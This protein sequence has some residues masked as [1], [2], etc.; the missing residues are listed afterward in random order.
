VLV[1]VLG[2]AS[3]VGAKSKTAVKLEVVDVN[4]E[5]HQETWHPLNQKGTATSDCTTIGQ[6]TDCDTTIKLPQSRTYETETLY[7]N[8]IANGEH[9]RLACLYSCQTP[10]KSQTYDGELS[11]KTLTV[12]IPIPLTHEIKRVKFK[13]VGSW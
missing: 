11:G 3:L 10:A 12:Q 8:G 6:T 2:L 5:T 4:V 13:I 7:V 9:V 1:F